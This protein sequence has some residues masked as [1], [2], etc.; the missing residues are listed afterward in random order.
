MHLLVG[1]A[2]PIA[3]EPDFLYKY[4]RDMFSVPRPQIVEKL[5]AVF[6][7]VE[8][9]LFTGDGK[10]KGK[11]KVA[12]STLRAVAVKPLPPTG[13]SDNKAVGFFEEGVLTGAGIYLSIILPAVGYGTYFLGRK[14]F[15]IA[16]RFKQ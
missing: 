3:R 10:G 13:Q 16:A 9:L 1:P 12:T 14:G 7:K 6:Q 4:N 15:E 11:G 5:P 2:A 8:D